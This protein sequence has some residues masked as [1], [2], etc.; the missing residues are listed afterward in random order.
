M[1]FSL[2]FGKPE[3]I[4]QDVKGFEET[5]SF[6]SLLELEDVKRNVFAFYRYKKGYCL[7]EFPEPQSVPRNE[8]KKNDDDMKLRR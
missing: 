6:S 2:L 8:D 5:F 3:G 4:L 1:I 7:T